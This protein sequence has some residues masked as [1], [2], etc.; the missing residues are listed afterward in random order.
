MRLKTMNRWNDEPRNEGANWLDRAFA[1]L[2]S[3]TADH[4][5]MFAVGLII[6]AIVS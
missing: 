6:G 2:R 4:W 1:Y 5:L 3:R